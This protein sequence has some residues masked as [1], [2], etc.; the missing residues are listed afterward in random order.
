MGR[1]PRDKSSD[2][3]IA[4]R[5]AGATA[6]YLAANRV[7]RN[8]SM[9][10]RH[11]EGKG[12]IMLPSRKKGAQHG[13]WL[14]DIDIMTTFAGSIAVDG[15]SRRKSEFDPARV[16]RDV[17]DLAQSVTGSEAERD[18][19][20]R[21]LWERALCVFNKPGIIHFVGFIADELV[22]KRTVDGNRVKEIYD[23]VIRAAAK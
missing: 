16:D 8:V 7:V 20:L 13:R 21:W 5:L 17:E 1:K 14:S 12:H 11:D 6:A 4:T 3:L 9:D 15:F 23:N 10:G 18:A 19:Y 22:E 2:L